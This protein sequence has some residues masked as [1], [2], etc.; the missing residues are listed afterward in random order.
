MS[1]E[2]ED[3]IVAVTKAKTEA[4]IKNAAVLQGL[5]ANVV[6]DA[7]DEAAVEADVKEANLPFDINVIKR[8]ARPER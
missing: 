5:V 1:N 2:S 3:K 7:D 6:D 4:D 8:P